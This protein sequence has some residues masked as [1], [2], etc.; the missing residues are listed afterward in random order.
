M[1]I[2]VKVSGGKVVFMFAG[3]VGVPQ[4]LPNV[5]EGF[6]KANLEDAELWLVG[7]G[8]MLEPLKEKYGETNGV[9]FCGRQ[10]PAPARAP[11]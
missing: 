6:V 11:R 9:R 3:N 4:D 5:I 2:P 1:D 8:V 7:G 10:P